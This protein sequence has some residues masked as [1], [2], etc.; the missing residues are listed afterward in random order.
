[1]ALGA[2]ADT[3]VPI[4]A[5]GAEATRDVG[6]VFHANTFVAKLFVTK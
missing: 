1:M 3:L 6:A 5:R 2:A 4:F